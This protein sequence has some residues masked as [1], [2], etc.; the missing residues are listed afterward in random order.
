MAA[1]RP[2]KYD[3]KYHPEKYIELSR[4]GKSKTQIAAAFEVN[5][6]T[7]YEWART[8][9]DFSDAV[10]KGAV[11]CEAHFRDIGYQA[12]LGQLKIN[13]E[14][15][16]LDVGLYVWITKNTFGW[17]EKSD[18]DQTEEN[19]LEFDFTKHGEE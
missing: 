12:M 1:G 15:V 3:K 5:R 7:I 8:H 16:K 6:D 18:H 9:K 13:G 11:L 2:P 4:K 19:E 14:K 10:K 17:N